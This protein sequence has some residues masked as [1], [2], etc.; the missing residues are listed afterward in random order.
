MEESRGLE[1]RRHD[2]RGTVPVL[3]AAALFYT[4]HDSDAPEGSTMGQRDVASPYPGLP[5]RRFPSTDGGRGALT[6]ARPSLAHALCLIRT[7][8]S[9][10]GLPLS[11]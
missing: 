7:P 9:R 2:D 3:K 4:R 1:S 6:N 5:R 11:G 10:A 8:Y